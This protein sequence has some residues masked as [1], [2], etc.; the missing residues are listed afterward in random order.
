MNEKENFIP[1]LFICF[2]CFLFMNALCYFFRDPLCITLQSYYMIGM[3]NFL[4]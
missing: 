3:Y 2:L 4:Q 1:Q